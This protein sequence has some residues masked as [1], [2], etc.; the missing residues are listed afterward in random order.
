MKPLAAC[1]YDFVELQER[2]MCAY[3][4]AY[5]LRHSEDSPLRIISSSLA[6]SSN[7]ST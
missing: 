2:R 7:L 6:A 3:A 1:L 5:F 4:S